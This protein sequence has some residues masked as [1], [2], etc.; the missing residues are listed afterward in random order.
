MPAERF[1]ADRSAEYR[2]EIPFA[3]LAAGSHLLTFEATMGQEAVRRDVR[4][5][6]R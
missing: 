6:M 5:E 3:R 1:P 4:F 2:F